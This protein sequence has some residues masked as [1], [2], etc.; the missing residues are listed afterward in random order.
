MGG[1]D[2][3]L[4]TIHGEPILARTA[5]IA[6]AA[7]LGPVLVCLRAEDHARRKTLKNANA[8][9]INVSDANEGMS[10]SLRIGAARALK[11][12]S[13]SPS[14]GVQ[15][16]GMMVLLPDMP[17]ITSLDLKTMMAAFKAR[18][19]PFLRATD[20]E[21][22]LGHPTLFPKQALRRFETLK[23]DAGAA[24]LLDGECLETVTIGARACLDLDTPED[25]AAWRARTNTPD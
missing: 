6:L 14:T 22:H 8:T 2:K 20:S 15:P 19:G 7:E 18:G 10:A 9:I 16:S 12:I 11:E 13:A 1:R 3:L 21:G 25:W 17:E 5:R 24:R 4:E 23:G